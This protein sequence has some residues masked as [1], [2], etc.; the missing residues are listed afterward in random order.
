MGNGLRSW[1]AWFGAPQLR[2]N[3]KAVRWASPHLAVY[4][5]TGSTPAAHPVGD[6]STSGVFLFTEERWPTGS[7]VL[8]ALQRKDLS[9][10]N[11]GCWIAVQSQVVRWGSDGVGLAFVPPGCRICQG[12][13]TDAENAANEKNLRIFL[14]RLFLDDMGQLLA[15]SEAAP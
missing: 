10:T 8:L 2:D 6:I 15:Q 3:R 12:W 1:K 4:Y 14:S 7:V 13:A 9:E 5:W 11:P